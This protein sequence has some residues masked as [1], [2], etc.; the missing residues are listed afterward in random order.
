MKKEE[1]EQMNL[2]IKQIRSILVIIA[3]ILVLNVI[4]TGISSNH[5]NN[6]NNN[7]TS[8]TNENNNGS[9]TEEETSTTEYDV[10]SF[11]EITVDEMFNKV[12]TS[13]Y[14]IVYVGRSGCGYCR[15]FLGAL[16]QAQSE[17]NYET[18]Y[19]D[20]DKV[21]TD[22]SNKMKAISSDL[23][24]KFGYTPMVIVYKDG[25]YQD[26]WVGYA[27]YSSFAS[28]LTGLGMTK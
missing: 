6:N 8:T 19:I 3:C 20:L 1:I 15:M 14:R 4:V 11:T 10:S 7:N 2:L 16:R 26:V 22:G 21:T 18:L 27:E 9:S 23:N 24:E 28:F 12:N 25:V 13:G 17:F 5:S